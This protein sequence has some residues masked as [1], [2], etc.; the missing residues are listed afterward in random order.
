MKKRKPT[1]KPKFAFRAGA[2]VK[3]VKAQAAGE[4][5]VRIRAKHGAVTARNTVDESRPEDAPLHE[6]FEWD[7]EKA[8]DEFRLQQARTIIRAVV[9]VTNP[10]IEPQAVY[11][12]VRSQDAESEHGTYEPI[13]VVVREP[14][15]FAAA[16]G[17]LKEKLA[18]AHRAI[19]ELQ[20]AASLAKSPVSQEK[21]ATIGR[22]L[23]R[24]SEA[25]ELVA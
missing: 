2:R 11:V 13:T 9:D 1:K 14:D 6:A 25:A 15:L 21:L 19:E 23:K 3:K 12:H 5:L 7:D 24:A 17:E 4:E 16:L 20:S 10:D 22:H 8:A 18:G